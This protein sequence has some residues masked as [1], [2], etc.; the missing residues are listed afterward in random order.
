MKRLVYIAM[1]LVSISFISCEGPDDFDGDVTVVKELKK[2]S[3]EQPSKGYPDKND[4]L[5]PI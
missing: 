3:V 5:P 2:D 1:A 4:N